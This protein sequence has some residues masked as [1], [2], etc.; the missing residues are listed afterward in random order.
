M[1]ITDYRKWKIEDH[2]VRVI[3]KL[4]SLENVEDRLMHEKVELW[5]RLYDMH[6]EISRLVKLSLVMTW[7]SIWLILF[8]LFNV[9]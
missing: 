3:K 7:L 2:H 1:I 8:L 9:L 6:K 5:S 4:A